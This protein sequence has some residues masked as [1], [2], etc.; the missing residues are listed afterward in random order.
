MKTK[1]TLCAIFS[2]LVCVFMMLTLCACGDEK[3]ADESPK[4]T[5]SSVTEA[6]DPLWKDATY[7]EDVTL[8]EGQT[9]ITVKVEAG[10][11]SINITV[12]TDET[13]LEDALTSIDLIDGDESQFGLYIK[14]VN[15]ILADYDTDGTYWAIYKGGEYLTEGANK[16]IIATG[17]SFELVRSK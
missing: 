17:D 14:T 16:T 4:S 1:K 5:T 2:L 10:K 13:T 12:N 3:A 7:T 6:S 9:S 11:K 8:G 15:G